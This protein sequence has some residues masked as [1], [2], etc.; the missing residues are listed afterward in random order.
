M[1]VCYN[2]FKE[3]NGGV[4]PF[5]GYSVSHDRGKYPLAL[6][7]GTI[8]AGR[9]IL[10]R[11]LGQGGFGITYVAKNYQTKEVVA[12]K[13]YFPETMATRIN[14]NTVS[15]YTDER[16][17]SFKYG[18]ECFLNESKTLAEFI[19]NPNIVRVYSYFE[20]NSTA[21]FVMEYVTGRSL[22]T[23]LKNNGGKISV[24]TAKN[25]LF[26]IMDAL[27]DVH[28][29]GIIHRDISPDN[30]YITSEG[31]VKLLD[32]GS[33]R[34]SLGDKS[35]SLDVVLKHGYAPKEQYT[36]RGRQGPYTDIYALAATFYRSITGKVPPDSIERMD[37]DDL[38][39]PSNLGV[40]ITK[41]DEDAII[42]ALSVYP[43]DR[44]SSMLEFKNAMTENFINPSIPNYNQ[45]QPNFQQ[46]NGNFN[47]YNPNNQKI[48]V[49]P[50][51]PQQPNVQQINR[52]YDY[53]RAENERLDRD[54]LE[55]ER[56]ERERLEKERLEKERIE[57]E[58]K[59]QEEKR[60]LERERLEKERQEQ[61]RLKQEKKEREKREKE[62]K[63]RLERERREKEE[64][65]R[66]E[67]ERKEKEK[68]AREEKSRIERERREKEQQEKQRLKQEKK[69]NEKREKE[70]QARVKREQNEKK[71]A[72][73]KKD[74]NTSE[75]KNINSK[76]ILIASIALIIVA[77]SVVGVVMFSV[78]SSNNDGEVSTDNFTY[79]INGDE[80]TINEYIGAE[81]EVEIP[82]TINNLSVTEIGTNA[83]YQSDVTKVTIPEGVTYIKNWA[84]YGCKNLTEINIPNSVNKIGYYAFLSCDSLSQI[85]IPSACSYDENSFDSG[86]NISK[87]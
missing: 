83:F 71:R 22:Q 13:E 73:A 55:K 85:S 3:H 81:K 76:V 41:K 35:R 46:N 24:Q 18:M 25:I 78:L 36:R 72:E 63:A 47:Q 44:F 58:R 19:G 6:P 74:N 64:K 70:E 37:E 7:H 45:V 87:R 11:V 62:E 59:E 49:R 42:K 21:Y 86:I 80:I 16:A 84:F 9:Y 17:E 27:S 14:S 50:N 29:K 20:E 53:Q 23:Y 10:G 82:S 4:C 12:V 56:L 38:I 8:L 75:K 60:R 79:S 57:R 54:K 43:I 31:K 39:Y 5:C 66:K 52:Q 65:E 30:I 61:I 40:N 32:F 1:N 34:Y 68:K 48:N 15:S 69:E 28:S 77:V 2:C 26:P 67:R 33:A 51:P